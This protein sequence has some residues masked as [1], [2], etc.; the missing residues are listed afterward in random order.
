MNK[1]YYFYILKCNDGTKYYGHTN[2]LNERLSEH[3]KG[4]VCSTKNKQPKLVY[5]EEFSSC[6][7]AFKREMQFK[8]GNTR[9]K[10]VDNLINNFSKEKCQG[11][12]SHS[13][14]C[15]LRSINCVLIEESEDKPNAN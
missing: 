12:N 4:N 11:F 13:N 2:N 1:I 8:N 7:E 5:Y 9:K 10:T 6:S 15:S 3:M 14:L